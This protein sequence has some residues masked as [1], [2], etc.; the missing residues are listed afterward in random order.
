MD[1]GTRFAAPPVDG[2]TGHRAKARRRAAKRV[3]RFSRRP[4]AESAARQRDGRGVA[5]ALLMG[6]PQS[7]RA[8]AP[9]SQRLCPD[10]SIR[11]ARRLRRPVDDP[12]RLG[13]RC[14][15]TIS[16]SPKRFARQPSCSSSLWSSVLPSRDGAAAGTNGFSMCG[17]LPKCFGMLACSLPLEESD[18]SC[19]GVRP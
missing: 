15:A 14:L 4:A 5:Q 16:Q 18:A 12:G 9:V 8:R 19:R 11:R 7:D 1:L 10:F 6:R 17:A 3:E 13:P 2:E